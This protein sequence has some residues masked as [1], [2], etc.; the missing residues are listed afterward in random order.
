MVQCISCRK[1]IHGA[2]D[3]EAEYITSHSKSSASE[4]MCPICK[5]AVTQR[6][7]TYDELGDSNSSM[8][9][10]Q[11]EHDTEYN[12]VC[13]F[14]IVLLLNIKLEILYFVL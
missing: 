6:R 14:K 10:L 11:P 4:Y 12:K 9:L 2:C 13:I 8:D 1:Y 7:D 5:N 3:P